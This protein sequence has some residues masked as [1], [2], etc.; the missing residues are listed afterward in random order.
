[1]R[2][3]WRRLLHLGY[4]LA[5][6]ATVVA[7][8]SITSGYLFNWQTKQ[9][10]HTG[11]INLS[12]D[13]LPVYVSVNGQPPKLYKKKPITLPYLLPGYYTVTLTK[14]GYLVWTKSIQVNSGEVVVNPAIQLFLAETKAEPASSEEKELLAKVSVPKDD[15]LD[16]RGNEIW[17]KPISR[18]YPF[19]VASD[20]FSLVGRFISPVLSAQ[21]F[22]DRTNILFQVGNEIRVIDRDGSND[23]VLVVL[24]TED[25]SVFTTTNNGKTLIYQDGDE[26]LRKQI[27]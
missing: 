7:I 6:L 18:T 19:T 17:A 11:L 23:N 26:T 10:V 14:D 24:T 2:S 27:Q 25:P 21:W 5:F 15:E 12:P 20:T 4:F 1:M 13:Q 8:V 9:V 22:P 3:H 16:V